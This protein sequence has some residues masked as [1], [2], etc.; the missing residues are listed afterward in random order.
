M[1]FLFRNSI[2]TVD[3]LFMSVA[4]HGFSQGDI[5]APVIIALVGLIIHLT[6]GEKYNSPTN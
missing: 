6:I 1:K 4:A 2:S 3:A 5:G